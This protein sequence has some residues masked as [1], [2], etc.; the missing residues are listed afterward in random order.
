MSVLSV[1]LKCKIYCNLFSDTAGFPD[2]DF[3]SVFGGLVVEK[4]ILCPFFS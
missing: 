4:V 1:S 2:K 3:H